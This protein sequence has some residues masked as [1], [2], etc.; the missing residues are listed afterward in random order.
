LKFSSAQ[1]ASG[2]KSSAN[3]SFGGCPP[4]PAHEGG[5]PILPR[6]DRAVEATKARNPP[7]PR[8]PRAKARANSC[9]ALS[10]ELKKDGSA[11]SSLN[12]TPTKFSESRRPAAE[13]PFSHARVHWLNRE[14]DS[15][16]NQVFEMG[17]RARCSSTD[18]KEDF[19]RGHCLGKEIAINQGMPWSKPQEVDDALQ[20]KARRHTLRHEQQA[21]DQALEWAADV[22]SHRDDSN[23]EIRS[24]A[25]VNVNARE[26]SDAAQTMEMAPAVQVTSAVTSA[27]GR[28]YH[29]RRNVLVREAVNESAEAPIASGFSADVP[30]YGRK[31][32]L[33]P[34][35]PGNPP[36]KAH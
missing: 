16:E 25:R 11:N 3:M 1:I 34:C 15:A 22:A 31:Q 9:G 8:A 26:R 13:S 27:V 14:R 29:G 18:R 12:S 35:V 2:R 5:N 30:T 6:R 7:V 21:A 23:S 32:M 24:H 10:R 20:S 28:D 17:P 33:P 19:A 4:K 36:L